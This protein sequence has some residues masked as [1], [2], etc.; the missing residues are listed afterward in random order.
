MIVL[1]YTFKIKFNAIVLENFRALETE[2]GIETG[3]F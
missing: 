1:F 2:Q 3:E